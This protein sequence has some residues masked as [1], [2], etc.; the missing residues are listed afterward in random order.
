M[1]DEIPRLSTLITVVTQKFLD[2]AA[3]IVGLWILLRTDFN[4]DTWFRSV[5]VGLL[6]VT[7][8]IAIEF[9]VWLK[10]LKQVEESSQP[11]TRTDRRLATAD[12]GFNAPRPD[13]S[14]PKADED[15]DLDSGPGIPLAR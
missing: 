9:I 3:G 8:S 5:I 6:L 15:L 10:Q 11:G 14:L 4:G 13:K 12:A 2:V 7:V 1:S